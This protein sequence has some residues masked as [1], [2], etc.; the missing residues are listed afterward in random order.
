MNTPETFI[1]VFSGNNSGMPNAVFSEINL[2]K[3]W[4]KKHELSGIL[5]FYPLNTGIYDWA[6]LNNYFTPQKDYQKQAPFIEK[7]SCAS[8][9]HLHF[10]NGYLNA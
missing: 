2:A 4:I 5:S 7:F 3:E 9:E 1:Y 10:E 6:I 8:I